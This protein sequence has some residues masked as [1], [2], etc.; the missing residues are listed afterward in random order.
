MLAFSSKVLVLAKKLVTNM[1]F[2][3]ALYLLLQVAHLYRNGKIPEPSCQSS[4]A[5]IIVLL[6]TI[7]NSDR[8]LKETGK[9]VN[10]R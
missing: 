3:Q 4:S 1:L 7:S 9:H 2:L 10:W 6:H 8:A 5:T